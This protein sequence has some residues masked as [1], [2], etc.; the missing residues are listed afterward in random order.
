M[1]DVESTSGKSTGD[2]DLLGQI[3]KSAHEA[4][5]AVDSRHRILCYNSVAERIFGKPRAEMLG[6]PF[7]ELL[8][9]RLRKFHAQ[10][11]D[12]LFD[13]PDWSEGFVFT[14]IMPCYRCNGEHFEAELRVSR[15]DAPGGKVIVANIIDLPEL[16]KRTQYLYSLLESHRYLLKRT[17]RIA[18]EEREEVAREVHDNMGQNA[19]A[20]T[21][22]SELLKQALDRGDDTRQLHRLVDDIM[23]IATN[24]TSTIRDL[25]RKLNP[26]AHD[27]LNMAE[28]IEQIVERLSLRDHGYDVRI[29]IDPE[30]DIVTQKM[31][32]ANIYRMAQALLNNAARHSNATQLSIDLNIHHDGVKQEGNALRWEDLRAYT[33]SEVSM[34]G[35]VESIRPALAM[36]VRDNGKGMAGLR[37]GYGAGHGLINVYERAAALGGLARISTETDR[38]TEIEVIVPVSTQ[39]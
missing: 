31:I 23:G 3:V 15:V 22:K 25:C 6:V 1:D 39:I 8:P 17:L 35:T 37:S 10:I 19:T 38:G 30:A 28:A 13:D 16:Q 4:V 2:R 7:A 32:R 9:N 18:E 14:T 27:T 33:T 24:C 34:A 5:I 29:N 20:I 26:Q 36:S 12:D 11:L 21:M